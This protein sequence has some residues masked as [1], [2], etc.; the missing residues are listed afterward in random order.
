MKSALSVGLFYNCQQVGI[1][2]WFGRKLELTGVIC[3]FQSKRDC[4]SIIF[5]QAEKIIHHREHEEHGE[6]ILL[7]QLLESPCSRQLLLRRLKR[8]LLVLYLENSF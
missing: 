3:W 1:G 7:T 6:I 4:E 2:L 5:D 8:L